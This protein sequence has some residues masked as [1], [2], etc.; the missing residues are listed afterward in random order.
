MDQRQCIS[1]RTRFIPLR[2]P[3]QRY[4][5]KSSCQKK[6]QN[7]YKRQKLKIDADYKQ[8]QYSAQQRWC[9]SHSDYWKQYRSRKP[10][11]AESNRMA[12][13]T[14]NKNR[15]QKRQNEPLETIAKITP[16]IPET[17]NLSICYNIILLSLEMIA[18]RERYRQQNEELVFSDA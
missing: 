17:D 11:Y 13:R 14:R 8:N 18:K 2:N 6:R 12:Q 1:C 3:N 10:V 9:E 16:L 7:R 5:S 4:C 15:N